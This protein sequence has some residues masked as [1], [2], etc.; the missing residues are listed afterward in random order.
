MVVS[1]YSDSR[2]VRDLVAKVNCHDCGVFVINIYSAERKYDVIN[3]YSAE[4][5]YDSR[6]VS[7][8]MFVGCV[9]G[10]I[11]GYIHIRGNHL[12]SNSSSGESW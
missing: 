6:L 1:N 4:R 5:K 11:D 9:I 7:M 8:G 12:C 10:L 2:I 3:I